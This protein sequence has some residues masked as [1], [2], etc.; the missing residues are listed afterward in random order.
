M[1]EKNRRLAYNTESPYTA[2]Q[3]S[4]Y[5][6]LALLRKSKAD[7][8]PPRP[9]LTSQDEADIV[10]LLCRQLETVGNYRREN[11]KP[12]KGKSSR[13]R[14]RRL[15]QDG[16]ATTHSRTAPPL[17]DIFS[18]ITLGFNTTVRHLESL[19]AISRPPLLGE[20]TLE[21][22]KYAAAQPV[23][24]IAPLSAVFVCRTGLPAILT[25][26]LPLLAATASLA[27]PHES[28]IRLVPLGKAAGDKLAQTLH[29]PRVGFIGLLSHTSAAENLIGLVRTRVQ[30]VDIPWL[31]E[32][33]SGAYLPVKVRQ[34]KIKVGPKKEKAAHSL[35]DVGGS[36]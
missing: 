4:V 10:D 23:E 8:H 18:Y 6:Q 11:I 16:A 25:S 17:P 3:W 31:K 1:M 19:A 35:R 15:M 2:A 24:Q 28:P 13:R 30:P 32:T 26:S 5:S 36:K 9:V 21:Q 14:K 7:L 12:S 33:N 34:T 20:A 22:P 27:F 29:Q